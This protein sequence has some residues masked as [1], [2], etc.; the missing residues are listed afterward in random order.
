[1]SQNPPFSLSNF[2]AEELAAALAHKQ[3]EEE[4]TKREAEIRELQKRLLELQNVPPSSARSSSGMSQ[5][6]LLE[7]LS[8]LLVS[9]LF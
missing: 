6:L 5:G 3:A 4:A 2:S 9:C 7:F 1:M 8:G